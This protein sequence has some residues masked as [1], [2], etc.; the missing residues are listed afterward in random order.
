MQDDGRD[1]VEL[2][3]AAARDHAASWELLVPSPFA[4]NRAEEAA[5]DTAFAAMA[6]AKRRL[7]DHVVATYGVTPD[8]LASLA[9]A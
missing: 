6:D 9:T 3:R 4:V 1:L 2:V 7:S 8:Q 5:E